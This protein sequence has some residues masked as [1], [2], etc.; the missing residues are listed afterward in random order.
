MR[1]RHE[2]YADD[3]APMIVPGDDLD[4]IMAVMVRAFDVQFG[5]AWTRKQVSD[6]MLFGHCRYGLIGS[7]GAEPDDPSQDAVGFFLARRIIDEEELLLFAIDPDHRRKG[8]GH[9]LLKRMLDE[10]RAA[11]MVRI[12]LEMR[13]DNPADALYAAHGF[14]AIGLRRGYYRTPDGS[15]IDAIS[16]ELVLQN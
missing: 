10:A 11:G 14:R 15:R 4:R 5:E 7:D 8:L 6:A 2:A 9:V 12:F 3:P 1:N 16:Q 13:R